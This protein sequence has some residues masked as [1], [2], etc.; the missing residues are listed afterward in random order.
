MLESD[1]KCYLNLALFSEIDLDR[2]NEIN[3]NSQEENS[4]E[5]FIDEITS[6]VNRCITRNKE[7]EI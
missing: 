7:L 5:Q 3:D 6:L 1:K 4:T 2:C